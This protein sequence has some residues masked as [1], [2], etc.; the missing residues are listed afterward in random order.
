M[1]WEKYLQV[2]SFAGDIDKSLKQ[3]SNSINSS[4]S[5]ASQEIIDSNIAS[6]EEITRVLQHGF[7]NVVDSIDRVGEGVESLRAD[8]NFAMGE[9]L[10]KLELI[11]GTL[12]DILQEI[13]LAEFEREARSFRIRA[14]DAYKNGWYKE[15]LS[16]FL[17]AEKRNYQDFAVLFS[18][19][20]I[21]LYH[22]T[23]YEDDYK[24][25]SLE[26]ALVYYLKSAKYSTPK[27]K[28]HAAKSYLFSGWTCYLLEKDNEALD[29]TSKA[30]ELNPDLAEACFQKAKILMCLNAPD[31]ALVPLRKSIE[32]DRNYSIKA[33]LDEDFKRYEKA[34]LGLLGKMR[35]EAQKVAQEALDS[36]NTRAEKINKIGIGR[37]YLQDYARDEIKI[38]ASEIAKATHSFR[39]GTLYG[40]LDSEAFSAKASVALF[41]A[42][43]GFVKEAVADARNQLI[44]LEKELSV[45]QSGW[46]GKSAKQIKLES[47]GLGLR[48]NI[49]E[50][51][52]LG[53]D[54][55]LNSVYRRL[56]VS[57]VQSITNILIRKRKDNG[58]YGHSTINHSYDLKSINGA[59]VVIDHATGLM[60]HQSGSYEYMSWNKAKVWVESLNSMGYAGYHDWRLP[61]VEEAASLLESSKRNGLYIDPIFS[62]KKDWIW[63]GD[64]H[65]SGAAW[66]VFFDDGLVFWGYLSTFEIYVRPVRSLK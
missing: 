59:K 34:V 17:E 4:I 35:T 19:A 23:E 66:I 15:S 57:Q 61:T 6:Q 5:N 25:P 50:L 29:Y 44:H 49:L 27:S 14:E 46:F 9:V 62:N 56:S 39:S 45:S 54:G 55:K 47:E 12:T 16:D 2:N 43:G 20:N 1:K 65:G 41:Q 8:F 36:V 28:K 58:F 53:V 60:W 30:I 24:E 42:V 64:K 21:Y 18:I 7:D 13:R 38:I 48:E 52:S 32:I 51:E 22:S 10:W 31:K 33:S 40:Y 11:Q 3:H 63:T 37:Y 26:K